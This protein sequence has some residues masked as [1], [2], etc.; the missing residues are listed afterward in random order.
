MSTKSFHVD[1]E[2]EVAIVRFDRPPAN[3]I[4]IS[5]A[6]EFSDYLDELEGDE[7][8]GAIVI[9]GTGSF[10]SAGL[11]LKV[12]P[13]YSQEQQAEMIMSLNELVG[14]LYGCAIPTVAAVNGHSIAGG[15]VLTLACDY[16][17][18]TE[19]DCKLG[20]TEARVG[21]PYPMGPMAVVQGELAPSAVRS[22][23]LMAR[24]FGPQ[25]ALEKG[26]LDELQPADRV[27]ERALEVA[28]DLASIPRSAYARIKRQ[29][30]GATIARIEEAVANRSDP[31]LE[32]W[33]TSEAVE[34]SAEVLAGKRET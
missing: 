21:I 2:G 1:R 11:D 15:L 7:A 31:L 5:T 14:R 6:T 23:V 25:A 27:L 10:F 22:V 8:T 29:V 26:I 34:A 20:L 28:R 3:A 19:A 13:T 4:D 33:V 24:N 30:R 16:R 32:S 18:G 9:T 17:V 12:V